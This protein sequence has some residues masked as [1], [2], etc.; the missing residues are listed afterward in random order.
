MCGIAGYIGKELVGESRISAT[1]ALM[2]RRGPDAQ[3]FATFRVGDRFGV[4]LHS[5]LSIIDL[6][7]R[8]HQPMTIDGCTVVF[9]GEIYNYVELRRRL[10]ER[11][12]V[13]RTTSDTEVLLQSYLVYGEQCVNDFEG[14]WAFALFDARAQTAFLSRDRFGEKPLVVFETPSGI[15]FG[16]EIK[17]LRALSGVTFPVNEHH[18]LRY[19]ANGYKAL[20]KGTDTFFDGVHEIPYATNVMIRSDGAVRAERYW[21]PR[22]APEP[23]TYAAAVSG[24]RERLLESMRIRLRADVPLAFCLSGGVDSA[25]LVSIAAKQ[26][27]YDVATFSIIDRDVRYDE[28]ENIQATID[29]VRCP[30]TFIELPQPGFF[31]RSRQLIE[32]HDAPVSTV[33]YYVHSFL[34]EAIARAGFRVAISGTAADEL[35]TGYYDHFLLHSYEM[36]EHT[37]AAEVRRDFMTHIVPMIRNPTLR[38]PDRYLRDPQFRA[39]VFDNEGYARFLRRPCPEGFTEE[40]FCDSLLR[41]RML[42]ELFHEVVPVILREDDLNSMYYSIENRSPYLDARLCDFAYRIPPEH[43]IRE[44]YA[45]QV[46]RE[47]V[48]G[49]LN[50]RVRRDRQKKGFNASIHSVVDT[51]RREMREYL[52]EDGRIFDFV[53]RDQIVALLTH[54]PA[55]NRWSKFLFQFVNAKMFLE[56]FS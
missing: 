24:F 4:F 50:D 34:S 6:D 53:D 49:I 45:K 26:F 27:G 14:M 18:L 23:M 1:L 9:N 28:R 38:D 17:F 10:E 42:N 44:G 12:V 55:T 11:G 33:S 3:R 29:D 47:A 19:L 46:L 43:L 40:R 30:H 35:V 36:R 15:F 21:C 31:D 2:R 16:S 13:F 51:E 56:S 48:S 52:L 25:S 32:Y 37:S 41:N 22:Y 8:S 39:H 7:P 20:A 54:P 5:R